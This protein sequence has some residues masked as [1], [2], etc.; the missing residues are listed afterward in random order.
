MKTIGYKLKMTISILTIVLLTSCSGNV[1]V[2]SLIET[3]FN[4]FLLPVIT[5]TATRYV[6]VKLKN[7]VAT[8][9]ITEKIKEV[10]QVK[11]KPKNSPKQRLSFFSFGTTEAFLTSSES[12]EVRKEN[13]AS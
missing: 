9:N 8:K 4:N 7:S 11:E 6:Q 3:G 13:S 2:Y 5:K 12:E 10:N 1:P